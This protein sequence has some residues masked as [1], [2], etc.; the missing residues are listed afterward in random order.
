M[1]SDPPAPNVVLTTSSP[2]LA[3]LCVHGAGLDPWADALITTPGGGVGDLDGETGQSLQIAMQQTGARQIHVLGHRDDPVYV[4]A[5]GLAAPPGARREAAIV[6]AGLESSAVATVR[7][8]V[9]M[10][11]RSWRIAKGTVITGIVVEGDG[12]ADN[13]AL[14]IAA[15]GR[16]PGDEPAVTVRTAGG[17]EESL[18]SLKV[19]LDD[20]VVAA[21][22]TDTDLLSP[23]PTMGASPLDEPTSPPPANR[24]SSEITSGAA[25]GG[26][27]IVSGP[28]AIAGD[29]ASG[30]L[31]SGGG[32]QFGPIDT[33][34]TGSAPGALS[35]G[36]RGTSGPVAVSDNIDSGAVDLAGAIRSGAIGESGAMASAVVS[37]AL[38]H[39]VGDTNR[40]PVDDS[41]LSY[42]S[43]TR[44]TAIEDARPDPRQDS[45]LQDRLEKAASILGEFLDLRCKRHSSRRAMLRMLEA[46]ANPDP[47]MR[48]LQGLVREEGSD[49]SVVQASF[50]TLE[51]A[52]SMLSKDE[53]LAVIRRVLH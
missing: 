17:R 34:G 14:E 11:A 12:S 31:G 24:A 6:P 16:R 38:S 7:R 8:A 49:L 45:S 27:E 43:H 47:L 46:G 3:W 52:Q 33:G 48:A 1:S 30:P 39:E 10:L 23:S 26:E 50:S 37:S 15:G 35:L 2:G 44:S 40:E 51:M 9:A 20:L 18:E 5:A 22:T 21:P 42:E 36:R 25:P 41:W 19:D 29:I 53:M 32:V 13:V 4:T 28:L